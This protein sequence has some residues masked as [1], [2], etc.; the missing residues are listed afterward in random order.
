MLD[1][2][3][4][5]IALEKFGTVSEAATRLRLT[6]SAVSKRIRGLQA[7]VGYPIVEPHGRRV[8]LT[9]QGVRLLERARPLV[10]ELRAL[11]GPAEAAEASTFSMALAD[12][13]AASWGPAAIMR[14]LGQVPGIAL[15]LHA[16]RSVLLIE[17]LRLGRYQI[18]LSTDVPT[19]RDLIRYP[20]IDEPLVLVNRRCARR[21]G[22]DAP[23]ITI[24][25]GSATWRTLEPALRKD[26]PALYRRS[27]IGVESFSAA[28]QMVKAGFGDGLVPLGLARELK[29]DARCYREVAG[30]T[31]RVALFVRKTVNH[32]PGFAR[33]RDALMREAAGCFG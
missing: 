2:I 25:P 32:A 1:G 17:S 20:V 4:A 18:G 28:V 13:I 26:H 6:Q 27:R 3:E 11:A 8:R 24:E 7:A 5:L 29:L 12:S 31:R 21:N 10:A 16:H 15:E 9:A 30:L 14:A 33:F 23:L 22:G 19:A